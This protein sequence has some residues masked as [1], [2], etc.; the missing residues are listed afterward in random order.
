MEEGHKDLQE[1]LDSQVWTEIPGH[2]EIVVILAQLVI[3]EQFK[4]NLEEE[5]NKEIQDLQEIPDLQEVQARLALPA[6]PVF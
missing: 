6:I 2:E 4:A 1:I 3:L 5:V